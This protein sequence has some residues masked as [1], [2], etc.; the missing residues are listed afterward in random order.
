MIYL[1]GV[2]AFLLNNG[3]TYHA[4]NGTALVEYLTTLY[5]KPEWKQVP[6]I[7]LAG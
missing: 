1:T 2:L 7:S 3:L 6:Y 5:L 4:A